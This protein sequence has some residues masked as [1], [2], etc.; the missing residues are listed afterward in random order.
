MTAN[1]AVM[2]LMG[3]VAR[4]ALR[5][6]RRM[7]GIPAQV[8]VPPM[9]QA[10]ALV[11]DQAVHPIGTVLARTLSV[12]TLAT[13]G[14]SARSVK[15][16]IIAIPAST[17]RADPVTP[18]GIPSTNPMTAT[19]S[20]IAVLTVSPDSVGPVPPSGAPLQDALRAVDVPSGSANGSKRQRKRRRH[21]SRD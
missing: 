12:T 13:A 8:R 1:G 6:I 19:A 20:P 7:V 15:S 4:A 2:E 21:C 14:E 9:A 17:T 16:A 18:F 5:T 3:P 10:R 11:L